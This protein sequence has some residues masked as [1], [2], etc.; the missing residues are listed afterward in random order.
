MKKS[1]VFVSETEAQVT[2]AFQKEACIFGT[3]EFKLW[4]EYIRV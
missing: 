4:R 1:I 3:E 2:K